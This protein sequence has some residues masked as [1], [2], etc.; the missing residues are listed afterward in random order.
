MFPAIFFRCYYKL[1]SVGV[2]INCHI[3]KHVKCKFHMA[4]TSMN[5]S[6]R[7]S[8]KNEKTISKYSFYVNIFKCILR[9]EFCLF[10]Y[11]QGQSSVHNH[12]GTGIF[13][14]GL[15]LMFKIQ[16]W[17]IALTII[18]TIYKLLATKFKWILL[19][20]LTAS[21]LDTFNWIKGWEVL[22]KRILTYH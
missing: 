7:R 9:C 13:L 17:T 18:Q 20:F 6:K 12:A 15:R 4:G 1:C 14:T 16:D 10:V 3:V 2:V 19:F 8:I 21:F 11:T 5:I 22:W